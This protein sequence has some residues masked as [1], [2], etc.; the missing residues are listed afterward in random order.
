MIAKID[1]G[2]SRET[3]RGWLVATSAVLAVGAAWVAPGYAGAESVSFSTPGSQSFV[4]PANVSKITISATGSRG[5]SDPEAPACTPGHGG[6]LEA[7]FAVTP[8]S[9]L[10]ITVGGAGGDTTTEAGGAG[11]VGGGGAGG[12]GTGKD[13]GGGGGGASTVGLSGG[14]PLLVAAG[15]GGCG[16]FQHGAGEGGGNDGATGGPGAKALGGA[17]GGTI[18][19]GAGGASANVADPKGAAGSAGQGG[20]GAGAPT[21]NGGGGGG[22]G[23]YFGGGGGGGVRFA[24]ST[25]GGGGGGSDFFGAGAFNLASTQGAGAGNG[26]VTLTYTGGP[27][28]PLP[29]GAQGPA[30]P[31]G[32]AGAQGPAGPAG[33]VQL[34]TCS[35]VTKTIKVQGKSKKVKLKKCTT[36][37]VSGVVKFTATSSRA[38]L[39]RGGMVYAVGSA[40]LARGGEQLALS[41]RRAL[42]AGRYQLT[43]R[44]RSGH[45]IRRSTI[46]LS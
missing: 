17:A 41:A 27:V 16:A 30:G 24:E 13:G 5:G 43:L 35:P 14:A 20:A 10:S 8:A 23:G 1:F 19:G 38:T 9:V 21:Q 39:S 37:L 25:A 28:T 2:R 6:Q 34:V 15:G 31:Q 40:V 7:T 26:Q 29:T 11:G 32:P 46:V 4:V 45:L 44:T 18:F 3:R 22:G 42:N 12:T 36:K 33:K